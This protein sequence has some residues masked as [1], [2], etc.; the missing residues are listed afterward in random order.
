VAR[1]QK[2]YND[3]AGYM[4]QEQVDILYQEHKETVAEQLQVALKRDKLLKL[5]KSYLLCSSF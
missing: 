4:V 2:V 1:D 3:F 5:I